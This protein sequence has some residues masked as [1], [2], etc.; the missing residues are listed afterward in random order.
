[1]TQSPHLQMKGS[2]QGHIGHIGKGLEARLPD[3]P[4]RDFCPRVADILD[5]R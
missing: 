2:A 3:N 1:M 4:A 5:N